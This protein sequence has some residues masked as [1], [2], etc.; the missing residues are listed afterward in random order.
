LDFQAADRDGLSV[1]GTLGSPAAVTLAAW[2]DLDALDGGSFAEVINIANSL[3]IRC[4]GDGVTG[5][6]STDG[7]SSFADAADFS[8]SLVGEGPIFLALVVDPAN[9]RLELYRDG[10]SAVLN[11]AVSDPIVYGAGNVVVGTHPSI[12]VVDFDGRM[13]HVMVFP[14]A[15]STAQ[16]NAVMEVTASGGPF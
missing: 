11:N 2:I 6:Y 1:S 8:G 14:S 10:V 13:R 15:L 4:T 7:G 5:Y 12:D 16:I 3:I 9:G